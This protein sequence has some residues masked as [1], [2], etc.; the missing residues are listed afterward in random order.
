MIRHKVF[1]G[2]ETDENGNLSLKTG[3]FG[4]IE[5]I[6]ISFEELDQDTEVDVIT[7]SGRTAFHYKGNNDT[8]F[9]VNPHHSINTERVGVLGADTPMEKYVNAGDLYIHFKNAGANRK[10]GFFEIIWSE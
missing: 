4:K 8:D 3:F 2:Q 5:E 6:L 10:L 9:P 1:L 7:S